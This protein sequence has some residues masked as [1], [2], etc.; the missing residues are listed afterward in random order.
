M[1]ELT[2]TLVRLAYLVGLWLFVLGAIRVLRHDIYGTRVLPR[3]LP[4]ATDGARNKRQRR[5]PGSE[6]LYL[7]MTAG[8]LAGTTVPLTT[9]TVLLGRTPSATVVL[10]DD[11]SSSRHARVFPEGKDWFIEDLGS[12]NGTTVGGRTISEPTPLTVGTEV[13]V[14]K[15]TFELRRSEG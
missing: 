3:R 6:N 11:F 13:K 7:V 4:G 1:T 8:T 9:S 5:T 10:E 2:V 15:N 14:G 12:T